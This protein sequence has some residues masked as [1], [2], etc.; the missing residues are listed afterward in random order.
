MVEQISKFV[1]SYH[2]KIQ[3]S[4]QKGSEIIRTFSLVWCVI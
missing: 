3:C 4:P 1:H 2:L